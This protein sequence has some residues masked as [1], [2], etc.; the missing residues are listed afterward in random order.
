MIADVG[1][2]REQVHGE[3]DRREVLLHDLR[4]VLRDRRRG[5]E[6][7]P[8]RHRRPMIRAVPPAA[9]EAA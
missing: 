2:Q 1:R 6:E 3:A 4:D 9:A 8:V 7:V 5:Q